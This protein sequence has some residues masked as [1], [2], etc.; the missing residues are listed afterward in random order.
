MQTNSC[1]DLMTRPF[2]M[3]RQ[4]MSYLSSDAAPAEPW[5]RETPATSPEVVTARRD[6]VNEEKLRILKMLE[7]G[8]IKADE[9]ARLMEALDRTSARPTEGDL[10]KRWIHI[11]VEKEGRETVNVRLPLALLRFGFTFGSGAMRHHADRARHD[12][13]RARRHAEKIRQRIE[14]KLTTKFGKDIDVNIG[15]A[16]GKA[17]EEVEGPLGEKAEMAERL[18]R[19]LDLD[20]ILEMAQKEGFDGKVLDVYDEDDDE[21][22]VVRLE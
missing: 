7:E 11:K 20:K 21:H 6:F 16:I 14:R 12:A 13:E 9:A 19:E 10:R 15:E 1:A 3:S 5:K 17:L 22:V 8:K 2:S 18:S 4:V